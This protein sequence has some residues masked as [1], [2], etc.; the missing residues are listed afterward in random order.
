V[1]DEGHPSSVKSRRRVNTS[2]VLSLSTVYPNDSFETPEEYLNAVEFESTFVASP[3]TKKNGSVIPRSSNYV[4]CSSNKYYCPYYI[5]PRYW[6]KINAAPRFDEKL[7]TQKIQH[8][9]NFMHTG[10]VNPNPF[11][12]GNDD[13]VRN[14]ENVKKKLA[15]LPVIQ[16]YKM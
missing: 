7:E 6:E 9:Y 14:T 13:R 8:F 16:R 2:N 11:L 15:E 5:K 12:E 4:N 10:K 3:Q 1:Q